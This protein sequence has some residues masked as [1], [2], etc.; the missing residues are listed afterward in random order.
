VGVR[1]QRGGGYPLV[2]VTTPK[3]FSLCTIS[4]YILY[5][6]TTSLSIISFQHNFS[7]LHLC[8]FLVLAHA[9]L[10]FELAEPVCWFHYSIQSACFSCTNG[11]GVLVSGLMP[12]SW[13][14]CGSSPWERSSH[15]GNCHTYSFRDDCWMQLSEIFQ[16]Q[17]QCMHDGQP[18]FKTFWCLQLLRSPK[19]S[20]FEAGFTSVLGV[21]HEKLDI[22]VC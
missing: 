19:L 15:Q 12:Q 11:N 22:S 16:G 13:A 7:S 10:K 21:W 20:W 17:I 6:S 9:N 5:S 14:T 18:R 4:L 2:N 3:S 8:N 1:A